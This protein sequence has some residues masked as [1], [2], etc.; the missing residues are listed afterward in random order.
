MPESR[1][2]VGT[3]ENATLSFSPLRLPPRVPTAR[4]DSGI[5]PG[6][7]RHK[8]GYK[9][10]YG[11][12]LPARP[13]P[14]VVETLWDPVFAAGGANVTKLHHRPDGGIDTAVIPVKL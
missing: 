14:G 11:R 10:K 4:R 5:E 7:H 12:R 2:A 13:Q 9:N 1:R 8:E 3:I 6:K